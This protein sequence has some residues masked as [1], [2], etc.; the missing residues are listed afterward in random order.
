MSGLIWMV[1]SSREE[2][3]I[4]LS[5]NECSFFVGCVFCVLYKKNGFGFLIL[6][7]AY[8]YLGL[9]WLCN[10]VN[11]LK[12]VRTAKKFYILFPTNNCANYN[13]YMG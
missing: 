4:R 6:H 3:R 7:E 2:K 13:I 12:C 11:E 9:M 10:V 8:L 1:C 5:T